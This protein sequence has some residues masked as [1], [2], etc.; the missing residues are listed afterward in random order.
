MRK[1]HKNA[2]HLLQQLGE[3]SSI[4]T[5][6]DESKREFFDKPLEIMRRALGFDMSVLYKIENLVE[7]DLILEVMRVLDPYSGRP[8]LAEGTK[9]SIDI[10]NPGEKFLNEVNAF[11]NRHISII[12]ISGAGCDLVGFIYLPE[13]LGGGYLFGGD[14]LGSDSAI[15]KYEAGVCE[16]MCN[17]LSS[18]LM[19]TQFEQLAIYDSLT[20][21]FNSRAIREEL[22][23]AFQRLGRK[24]DSTLTIALADIDFFKKINDQYGHIQG[25]SVLEEMGA[26]ISS[27]MRADFDIA[28]RYGGEEF[29][30]IFEDTDEKT[31]FNIIDRLRKR[32]SKH[33]FKGLGDKGLPIKGK[34]INLTMSFGISYIRTNHKVKTCNELLSMADSALYQSKTGGRNCI[35]LAPSAQKNSM[36]L[37]KQNQ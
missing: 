3:L 16:V 36:S 19:K 1:S 35:N 2:E 15:Q 18:C 14:H 37:K 13:S 10:T 32:V 17:L 28:G 29:L 9:I 23:K 33:K 11:N 21:V 26:L 8:D 20:G 31:T 24:K 5:G 6:L 12:N 30:L 25:D 4:L 27:A 7:N 34:F 22:G